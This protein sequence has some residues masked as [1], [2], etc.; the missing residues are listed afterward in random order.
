VNLAQMLADVQR[1]CHQIGRPLVELERHLG[2]AVEL[3]SSLATARQQRAQAE[4]SVAEVMAQLATARADLER[5]AAELADVRRTAA[6]ERRQLE[7]QSVEARAQ[8][9][10]AIAQAS[11]DLETTRT[12]MRAEHDRQAATLCENIAEL[13]AQRDALVR[14][15]DD[16][17]ARVASM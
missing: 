15:I 16:A 9:E 13:T 10:R 2:E 8:T 3:E 11:H 17:K 6:A 14:A 12:A 1:A 7:Q 4:A 5:V